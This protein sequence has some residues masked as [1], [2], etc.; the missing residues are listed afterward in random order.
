[1][2]VL[3]LSPLAKVCGVDMMYSY[4]GKYIVYSYELED[5]DNQ[6]NPWDKKVVETRCRV[7]DSKNYADAFVFTEKLQD[8]ECEMFFGDERLM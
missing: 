6:I 8:R 4:T 2:L 1:M 3:I 5:A 7:F